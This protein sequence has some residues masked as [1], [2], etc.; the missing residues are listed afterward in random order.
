MPY[1]PS[2]GAKVRAECSEGGNSMQKVS[3]LK[4]KGCLPLFLFTLALLFLPSG[5]VSAQAKKPQA[6]PTLIVFD[7]VTEK[8]VEKSTGNMLTEVVIDRIAG[9]GRYIVIGQ[10]DIDKMMAWEE[11]KQLQ[12]CNDTSCLVQIAGA[13]GAHYYIE[14]SIGV[15]GNQYIITLKQIDALVVK[16]ITRR[17]DTVNKDETTLVQSM[18]NM[19]DFIF[20]GKAVDKKPVSPKLLTDMGMGFLF[21]GVG[22][23]AIGGVFQGLSVKA[24]NDANSEK[25]PQKMADQLSR[26]DTYKSVAIAGYATGGALAVTGAVLWIYGAVSKPPKSKEPVKAKVSYFVTPAISGDA[27]GIGL[28][29]NW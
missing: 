18:K 21:S 6:L 9:L 12:G 3:F 20:T 23:V 1:V 10:K 19:V 26:M 2:K 15:I 14:G 27:V 24:H 5:I 29:G 7:I 16:V 25:D 8:G 4:E 17:T 28:S 11:K 22:V 13:L